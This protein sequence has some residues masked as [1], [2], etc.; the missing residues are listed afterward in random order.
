M[1]NQ[2][3]EITAASNLTEKER[4]MRSLKILLATRAGEQALDRNFGLNWD[5]LDK[6]IEVAKAMLASEI[7]EKVA[8]YVPTV[9]VAAVD[10]TA[11][12]DGTLTPIVS[13]EEATE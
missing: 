8:A 11:G 2:T 12:A 1:I 7:I 3:I 6:P 13:V 5:C 4:V 10:F 9:T